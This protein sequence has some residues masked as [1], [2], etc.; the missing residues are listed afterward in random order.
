MTTQER[1]LLQDVVDRLLYLHER[2]RKHFDGLL[3]DLL[4]IYYIP[5]EVIDGIR[6]YSIKPKEKRYVRE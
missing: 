4:D 5:Y 1:E 6:V 2:D 3:K